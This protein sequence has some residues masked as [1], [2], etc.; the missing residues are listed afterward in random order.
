MNRAE[1]EAVHNRILALEARMELLEQENQKF[2]ART[3]DEDVAAELARKPK[4][5]EK[6]V[7]A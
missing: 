4:G 7:G 2:K 3:L 5:A 6:R 1:Y